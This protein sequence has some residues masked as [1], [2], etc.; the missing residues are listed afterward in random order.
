M[1]ATASDP[2]VSPPQTRGSSII[3][4]DAIPSW[5][6]HSPGGRHTNVASALEGRPVSQAVVVLWQL[7]WPG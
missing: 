6:E 1:S 5:G 4:L 2:M 3:T 7:C